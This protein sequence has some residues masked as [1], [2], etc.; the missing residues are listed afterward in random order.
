MLK[1]V[2]KAER[3]SKTARQLLDEV[4][5]VKKPK[6]L[7]TAYHCWR[8]MDVFNSV[9]LNQTLDKAARLEQKMTGG[10]LVYRCG[11]S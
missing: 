6:D 2:T 7:H 11:G 5:V 10:A 8:I 1:Y 4:M 3:G 9:G